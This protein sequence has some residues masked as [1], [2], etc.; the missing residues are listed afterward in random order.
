MHISGIQFKGATRYITLLC[1]QKL[2]ELTDSVDTAGWQN[3][4]VLVI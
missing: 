1:E 4:T 3:V 2:L